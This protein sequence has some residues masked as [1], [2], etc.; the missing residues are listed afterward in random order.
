MV[1][2]FELLVDRLDAFSRYKDRDF[3]GSESEYQERLRESKTLYVGNI[4]FRTSELHL[5]DLFSRF[6]AVDQVILGINKVAR[7]PCGF[8]FVSF[9]L[10][11]DAQHAKLFMDGWSL[12]GRVIRADWDYGFEEGRQFGRGKFGGQ[13]RDDHRL[14]YDEGRG[15]YSKALEE[16]KRRVEVYEPSSS[17]RDSSY[18]GER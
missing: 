15:G 2:S 9:W 13:V 10:R 6:G 7:E 18:R 4:S 5:R 14:D 11:R 17:K 1:L 16:R 8:A 12:D 3:K